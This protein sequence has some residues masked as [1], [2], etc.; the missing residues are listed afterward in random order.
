MSITCPRC[1]LTSFNAD[2]VK[3]RYCGACH[4]F[5]DDMAMKPIRVEM[6]D[7]DYEGIETVVIDRVTFKDKPEPKTAAVLHEWFKRIYGS[8]T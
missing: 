7:I 2:D 3:N 6:G 1:G 5:H 8:L 4:A